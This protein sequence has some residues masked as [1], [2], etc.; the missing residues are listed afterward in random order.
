MLELEKSYLKI[1][2][3]IIILSICLYKDI[4]FR[5]ISKRFFKNSFILIIFV[6]ILDCFLSSPHFVELLLYKLLYFFLS[7][8]ISIILYSVK[9]IGGSDGK[10]FILIFLSHPLNFLSL[11]YIISFFFFFFTF[12]LEYNIIITLR[13]VLGKSRDLFLFFFINYSKTTKIKK[14]YFITSYIFINFSKLECLNPDKYHIDKLFIIY[15]E[16]SKN[17]QLLAQYRPPLVIFCMLSYLLLLII[18]I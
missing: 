12:V 5:K 13:N 16:K 10:L 15:N 18:N 11:S 17:L 1:L 3:L 7:S 2:F 4:K 14:F 8:T 6:I 9:I